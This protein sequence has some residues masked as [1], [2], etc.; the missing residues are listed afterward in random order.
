MIFPKEA[1]VA[2]EVDL[3]IRNGRVVTGDGVVSAGVAVQD[4]VIVAVAKDELLPPAKTVI[5]VKGNHILPGIVDSEAHPG[6]YVPF[7]YDMRT[8]SRAAAC[9]GVTT[10]GIQAP[11]TRL[12]TKPFKEFVQAADVVPFSHSFGAAR[13]V[14]NEVSA[15]DA[16]LTFMIETD[17]QAEEIP[18]Y[19]EEYGVTSYKLYMQARRIPAE[20][21]NW[22]SRRAGLGVGIDDGTLYKVFEQVAR[23]GA[24]AIASIHPENWEIARVF[25]ERLREVGRTDLGAWTD[26]S[27]HLLEAQH[28]RAYAYIAEKLGSR[29]YIQ[30]ATTPATFAEIREAKARGVEIYAQTGPAWLGFTPVDGWRI[31]VPL[32][33]EDAQEE[34]WKA[35][36]RGDVDVVGSDHVVAWDPADRESMYSANIWDCRTGFSRVETFLPV[37]L[38]KGVHEGR[39]SLERLVQVSCENPAKIFGLYPQKGTI[40]VGSDAD[41]VVV[42]LSRDVTVGKEHL[43]TRAGWSIMEGRTY[44]GWPIMTILRGQVT[45]QWADDSPGPRPVGEPTGRYV[46]RS[47]RKDVPAARTDRIVRSGPN[48][49]LE[50]ISPNT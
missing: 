36:A 14:I 25:E 28:V 12:G 20:D 13:E 4:G 23:F 21:H 44:H 50:G 39:I 29:M 47:V 19:C 8:E 18:L 35:L 2:Q 32:R 1:I 48:A 33:W 45:A 43:N 40:A 31:N 10:W 30:H 41:M 6:C 11:S 5:D 22:P 37:M 7:D 42:D 38:T 15:V 34:L 3:V 9:A 17:E 27:P 49:T 46:G 24:P 16:F 26:R